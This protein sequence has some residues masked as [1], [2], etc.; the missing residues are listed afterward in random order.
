M[1]ALKWVFIGIGL[2]YGF[3]TM[4]L[5]F[6]SEPVDIWRFFASAGMDSMDSI[7]RWFTIA[8][9]TLFTMLSIALGVIIGQSVELKKIKENLEL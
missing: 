2:F 5:M 8:I 9:M 4:L 7:L 6:A 1:S 3:G